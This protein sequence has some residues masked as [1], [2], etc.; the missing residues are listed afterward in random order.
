M[1]FIKRF[2][3]SKSKAYEHLEEDYDQNDLTHMA[4]DE[5]FVYNFIKK[6]GR[7]FYPD[8][9]DGF[10]NELLKLLKYLQV[11]HF[12]VLERSYFHFMNKLHIPVTDRFDPS[13]VMLGGCEFLIANEGAIMTTATHTKTYRNDDLP[14]R[15]VIMALSNQI[16]SNKS[17]A[18]IEINNKYEKPPANI[19][20]MSIFAKQKDDLLGG[21]W[22]ETYLFLIEN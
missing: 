4:M 19:Q 16:V 14:R 3:S 10:K 1:D 22:Y 7:F 18:L 5:K 12:M 11:D 21:K 8:D 6:G 17:Q 2:F 9:M 13:A 15:R 20:T